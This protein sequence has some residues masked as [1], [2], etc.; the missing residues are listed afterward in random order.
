MIEEFHK[1][2]GK[3][4]LAS[5]RPA[6]AERAGTATVTGRRLDPDSSS[7]A[8]ERSVRRFRFPEELK[9]TDPIGQ[10]AE[11]R[12]PLLTQHPGQ[13]KSRTHSESRGHHVRALDL[14][15]SGDQGVDHRSSLGRE[16]W[17]GRLDG[18]RDRQWRHCGTGVRGK[19]L[20]PIT[21]YFYFPQPH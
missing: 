6:H 21:T 9:E 8:Q 15:R 10:R 17:Q 4:I 11:W 13:P 20:S 2:P 5:D 7:E 12:E 14:T 16:P 19:L 18:Q 1:S 3:T